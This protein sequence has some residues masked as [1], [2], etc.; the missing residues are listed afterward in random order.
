MFRLAAAHGRH[1]SSIAKDFKF[2]PLV[3]NVTSITAYAKR[4][5]LP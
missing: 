1:Y 2:S 3:H 4:A 5:I